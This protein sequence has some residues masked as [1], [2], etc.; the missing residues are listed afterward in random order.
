[1]AKISRL[2]VLFCSLSLLLP[3]LMAGQAT[4][5]RI[6][7]DV[8]DQAGNFLAGVTATAINIVNRAETKVLSGDNG[9]FRFLALAPGF[10]QVSFDLEGY[11]SYVASGIQLSADQ[12]ATLHVKLEPL[13]GPDGAPLRPQ[14]ERLPAPVAR[15][16][17]GIGRKWQLELAVGALFGEPDDLNGSVTHEDWFSREQALHYLFGPDFWSFNYD[18]VSKGALKPLGGGQP[19]TARVR[20]SLS[21]TLS[22]ALGIGYFDHR[23]VST[24]TRTFDIS[25]GLLGS[26][27][28]QERFSVSNDFPDFRLG[29]KGLF[30]HAGVQGSLF[31]GR[32]VRLA[33]FAHA[34]WTFAE[35]SYSSTRRFL[36]GWTGQDRFYEVAMSGKGNGFTLEGGAK[37]EVAVWRGLGLF[38]EGLYQ[39]C[40]IKNVTGDRTASETINDPGA[41][42][43]GSRT[44]VNSEGPWRQVGVGIAYPY[45]HPPGDETPYVPFILDLGGPGLRAGVFFRF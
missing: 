8:Q 4:N 44:T 15:P 28:N 10:Y 18:G 34:G 45:I 43:A 20:F 42:N 19:L 27:G 14:A 17:E 41:P 12:S 30:P 36:D 2:A 13:L 35:C 6:T 23:R 40:R 38:L 5:A 9:A 29:A 39:S 21:K 22:L 31:V 7:G 3:A 26:I 16:A 1:M 24:Y 37:I 32:R 11:K 33:A 25:H